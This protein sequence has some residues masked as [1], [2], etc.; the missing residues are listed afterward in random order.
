MS[1]IEHEAA[2]QIRRL[3][4]ED[5][6]FPGVSGATAFR[7]ADLKRGWQDAGYFSF[8]RNG[9]LYFV[10]VEDA[11]PSPEIVAALSRD[12]T[13]G[14]VEG[15]EQIKAL[16]E[17]LEAMEWRPEQNMADGVTKFC[18]VCG[19]T[20]SVYKLN[21][22]TARPDGHWLDGVRL[23]GECPLAQVLDVLRA[24][25]AARPEDT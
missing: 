18:P 15:D 24:T 12:R 23:R 9:K 19:G 20:P 1:E 11:E 25:R 2:D 4:A 21:P 6:R 10:T 7:R 14:E 13:P 17:K 22:K 5:E 16:L 3:L 8:E